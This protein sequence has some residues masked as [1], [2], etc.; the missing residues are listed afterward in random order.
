MKLR[1]YG[2]SCAVTHGKRERFL[3]KE[4]LLS[5]TTDQKGTVI[6]WVALLYLSWKDMFVRRQSVIKG[7]ITRH[8]I[9]IK[10]KYS[11]RTQLFYNN[12]RIDPH[13]HILSQLLDNNN[14]R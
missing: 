5:K 12:K 10:M 1:M 6:A 2:M 13:I 4:C 14:N 9:N 3:N 7:Y 11:S 8:C